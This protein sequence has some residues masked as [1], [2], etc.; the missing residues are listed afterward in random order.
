MQVF[1]EDWLGE[2]HELKD[3]DI[4]KIVAVK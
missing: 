4:V 3:G 1:G 2:K